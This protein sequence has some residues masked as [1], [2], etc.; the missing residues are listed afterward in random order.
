MAEV[1]AVVAEHEVTVVCV[2]ADEGELTDERAE[3]M[4]M[5]AEVA[6]SPAPPPGVLDPQPPSN[7]DLQALSG[8]GSRI[9]R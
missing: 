8:S 1:E 6:N 9:T 5:L 3:D 4:T 7:T 2:M